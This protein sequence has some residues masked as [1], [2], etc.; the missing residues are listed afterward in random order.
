MSVR[1]Q[2]VLATFCTIVQ[3]LECAS[4]YVFGNEVIRLHGFIDSIRFQPAAYYV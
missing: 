2:V 4:E 3:S 1:F